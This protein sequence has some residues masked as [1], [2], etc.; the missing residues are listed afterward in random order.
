VRKNH[1]KFAM[2]V[3]MVV[4]MEFYF[5]FFTRC[6]SQICIFF[7]FCNSIDEVDF[8]FAL[9]AEFGSLGRHSLAHACLQ[10]HLLRCSSETCG[11]PRTSSN[12]C[13]THF[14]LAY[15]CELLCPQSKHF[16]MINFF[17]LCSFEASSKLT[18]RS[19]SPC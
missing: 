1:L 13:V 15:N 8:R 5:N 7:V 4:P 17:T 19:L 18:N 10:Q 16:Q 14:L 2:L 11:R 12:R 9:F 6:F 3:T